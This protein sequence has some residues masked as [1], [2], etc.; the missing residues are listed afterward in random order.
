MDRRTRDLAFPEGVQ[1]VDIIMLVYRDSRNL[2]EIC[3]LYTS[4][5]PQNRESESTDRRAP[6]PDL[7]KT[8]WTCGTIKSA[9]SPA[10]NLLLYHPNVQVEQNLHW[11]SSALLFGNHR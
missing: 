7:H 3:F 6:F 4:A 9:S 10:G 2:A 5:A 8:G 1:R 11:S